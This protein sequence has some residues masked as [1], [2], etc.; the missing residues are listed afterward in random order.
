MTE[1]NQLPLQIIAGFLDQL[2][3]SLP[4]QELTAHGRLRL[5]Q[6]IENE[7]AA[8]LGLVPQAKAQQVTILLSDLRGF[9]QMSEQFPP[10]DV[11]GLLNRY[12]TKMN[13][14]I[15]DHE[16][17]IDKFMGDAI[18]VLFGVHEERDDDLL[19]AIR[20]ATHMQRAMDEINLGNREVGMP[21]LFM[22]IGI[23]TGEVVAG[24]VGSEYHSEFTVI[25]DQVNLASRVEAHSLRGQVLLSEN[26]FTLAEESIEV[27]NPRQ[28]YI[29]GK[30]DPVNL[31]ELKAVTR[32]DLIE[33]PSR[34]IRRGP[35]VDVDF[36]FQ[37]HAV[38]GK[39]VSD[40]TQ[41]GHA[42]DLSYSGLRGRVAFSVEQ[43]SDL[44]LSL[45]GGMLAGEAEEIYAKV[46][47]VVQQEQGCEVTMEFTS[48][49]LAVD[50]VIRRYVD[51]IVDGS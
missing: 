44:K 5:S 24:N 41:Q 9:T 2:D 23:N 17:V 37:F 40:E 31:Y 43:M 50:E 1:E 34:E 15:H 28:V 22:G 7:L 27:A 26:S 13:S 35:R 30:R 48:M 12:F 39:G 8:H 29:K 3:S 11:I 45:S 10:T 33:V 42:L 47:T 49:P 51:R 16:G 21:E 14:I 25:G 46:L 36:P 18:M 4:G 38:E 6:L 20:C 19:R 32:P